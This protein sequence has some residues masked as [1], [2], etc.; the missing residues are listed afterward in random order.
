MSASL[1]FRPGIAVLPALAL[2]EIGLRDRAHWA[3]R[4]FAVR[5]RTPMHA[6]N[7]RSGASN[8]VTNA[9]SVLRNT[10]ES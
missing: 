8:D 7:R 9:H 5:A 10:A 4:R 3:A 2:T 1:R 6:T